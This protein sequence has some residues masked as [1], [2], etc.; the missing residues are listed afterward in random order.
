M[1]LEIKDNY[2]IFP[3]DIRGV[4][5]VG[6]RAYRDKTILRNKTKNRM[7]RKTNKIRKKKH[8]SES[9]IGAVSAYNGILKYVTGKGL[10]KNH[11]SPVRE[12]IKNEKYRKNAMDS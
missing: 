12:L 2:Q 1:N 3:V 4:D 9:D 7:I 11:L 10:H 6:Y 8:A 5:F